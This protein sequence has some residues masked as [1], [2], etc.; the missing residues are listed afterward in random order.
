MGLATI[1]PHS[2]KVHTEIHKIPKLVFIGLVLTEIQASKNVK[3]LQTRNVW[4]CRQIPTLI[5]YRLVPNPSLCE[6]GQ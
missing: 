1:D 4:K 3:N 2:Q 6:I 5:I